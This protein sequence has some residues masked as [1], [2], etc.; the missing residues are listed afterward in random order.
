[1]III[2]RIIIKKLTVAWLL[3]ATKVF[4]LGDETFDQAVARILYLPLVVLACLGSP[5]VP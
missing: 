5:V 2:I 3:G 4:Y 1:M